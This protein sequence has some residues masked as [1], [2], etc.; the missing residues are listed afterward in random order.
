MR[1]RLILLFLVLTLAAVAV[2]EPVR[3]DNP[4]EPRDGVETL[5]LEELWRRGGEDDDVLFG[6]LLKALGDEAGNVYLL[7]NQL[8]EV[9]V[10][11]PDGEYLKTLSREGDGPGEVRAPT[12]MLWMPDG[13]L[14]IVQTFP[15]RIIQV[16]VEGT[17]AGQFKTGGEGAIIA[18]AEARSQGGNLVMGVIDIE[19]TGGGAGQDRHIFLGSYDAEGNELCRYTGFDVHW[20]FPNVVF[21]EREQYFALF[22]RWDLRDDGRVVAAE[23]RDE[24]LFHVYAVDG[25]L[26]R[27]VTREFEA[28]QRDDEDYALINGIM[29]GASRQFPF[30]IETEVEKTESPISLLTARENDET[31]IISA[32]GAREQPEGVFVTYD[33]FDAEGV[34]ARQ[35]QLACAGDGRRDGVFFLEDRVLVIRGLL[36]ALSAQMGGSAETEEEPAPIEVVCY[37]MID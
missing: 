1:T 9:Q 22:G 2:A 13:S 34:F 16:D 37:R 21:R 28:W 35:V 8:A 26:E 24:Y 12:D 20:D 25:T 19:V 29:E 31:W 32:R 6:V 23:G 33:V 5:Q 36:D 4:A 27:V 7:D 14:G 18:V 3:V 11:A 10:F 17:P 15:G 30:P